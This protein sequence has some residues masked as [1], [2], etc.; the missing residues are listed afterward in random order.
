MSVGVEKGKIDK[1][2]Q[3]KKVA[4][5]DYVSCLAQFLKK[6]RDNIYS[7]YEGIA[8]QGICR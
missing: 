5:M 3:H 4:D 8:R 2:I 1:I 6:N 7:S